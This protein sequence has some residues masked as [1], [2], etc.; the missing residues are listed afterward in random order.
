MGFIWIY[1]L[2]DPKNREIELD[3]SINTSC[4]PVDYML[5]QIKDWSWVVQAKL[6]MKLEGSSRVKAAISVQVLGVSQVRVTSTHKP[7]TYQ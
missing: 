1:A 5:Q 4:D 3:T 6:A 2:I 7:I